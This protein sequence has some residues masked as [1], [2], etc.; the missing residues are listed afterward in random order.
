[1]KK[2]I[3]IIC[4]V[5]LMTGCD[6]TYNLTIDEDTFDEKVNMSFSKQDVDYNHLT[7][8][9]EDKIPAF[10]T[11]DESERKFY[12]V[13]IVDNGNFYD[14]V[15]SYKHNFETIRK[16]Y[17]ASNCYQK[18]SITSNDEEI[19][20]SSGDGIACFI[21]DDGLRADSMT[22][23]LTTEL[24]VL[25]NNADKINGNTYTWIVNENNYLDK[26]VYFRL[27]KKPNL[28]V[29]KN[30]ASYLMLIVV[31]SIVIV[32]FLIYLFVR[33]KKKKSNAF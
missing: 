13:D 16:S 3:L 6:V 33:H 1:M 31:L 26:S 23:N 18:M 20:I 5:F 9:L 10:F 22:I 28:D 8:Y 14:L 12:N 7:I 30:N 4:L 27:Q 15:Y 21:G 19:V 2:L 17:F 29:D 32:G 25:D 11:K 24:K